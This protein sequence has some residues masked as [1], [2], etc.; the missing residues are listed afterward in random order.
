[1]P[2]DDLIKPEFP[3][4]EIVADEPLQ[5]I[6]THPN[7]SQDNPSQPA[8]RRPKAS[9]PIPTHPNQNRKVE[10]SPIK[11]LHKS[12]KLDHKTA[13]PEKIFKGLSKHTYDVLYQST[14]GA[15]KPVREIQLTKSELMKLT[16]LSENTVSTHIKHLRESGMISTT[17]SIGKH[18]GSEI[19]EVFILEELTHPNL[20]QPIPTQGKITQNLVPIPTQNLGSVGEGNPVDNIDTYENAK[21]LLRQIQVM[22]MRSQISA[23]GLMNYGAS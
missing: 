16:G 22:M 18:E 3:K 7:P 14:R 19:Y 4:L 15:I 20:S 2:H 9:Q 8:P 1:M 5:P 23:P 21:V 17:M 10:T 12:S 13:I 11:E 6:P